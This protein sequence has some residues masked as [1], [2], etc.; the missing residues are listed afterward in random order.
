MK[1][2]KRLIP[3]PRIQAINNKSQILD[4]V[5]EDKGKTLNKQTKSDRL[6]VWLRKKHFP[7]WVME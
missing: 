3:T 7:L 4:R 6:D 1:T 5:S 2:G